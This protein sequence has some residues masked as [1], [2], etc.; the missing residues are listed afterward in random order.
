MLYLDGISI[1]KILPELK[2]DILNKKVGKIFQSS[3]LSL[4]FNFGKKQLIISCDSN[5]PIFY[6]KEEKE[7]RIIE[8]NFNFLMI[9]RKHIK[10]SVLKKLEQIDCDRI[11]KFTFQ[12]INVLGETE[13]FFLYLEIMG[14]SSN[15]ILTDKK[16]NIIGT[17]K[18][19]SMEENSFRILFKGAKYKLPIVKKKENPNLVDRI[20][21]KKYLEEEVILEKINGVGKKTAEILKT[22]EDLKNILELPVKPKI[23]FKEKKPLFATV[24]DI[25]PEIYD[26][27]KEFSSFNKMVN[28]YIELKLL[29]TSFLRLKE[30]L[31]KIVKK[32]LKK[33]Q[34]TIKNIEKDIN[35]MKDYKR[36]KELGDILA[37]VLYSIKKGDKIVRGYDFYK[38]KEIEIEINAFLSP[39]KNLELMYRKYSKLKKGLEISNDRLEIFFLR[40]KYLESV[41]F[42]IDSCRKLLELENIEDE[43]KESKIIKNKNKIKNKEKKLSYGMIEI[44]K[45]L[46]Y[47][48]RNNKE[49]DYLTFKFSNKRDIWFHVKD[50]PG[51]HIIVKKED[52][53]DS[54]DFI[55]KIAEYAAYYSKANSLEKV[56]VDYTERKN[57][58]KPKGSSLGFVTYKI[59]N[60]II[61]KTP[62][63]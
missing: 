30:K 22:Y 23:Y 3:P 51:S 48:G 44:N 4:N 24:L 6:L 11:I 33:S 28:E 27:I 50:I 32:E 42:F 2:V 56:T 61:V 5:F 62:N 20:K 38:N 36:Y 52:F 41:L 63:K 60:S 40:E 47:Y 37:S 15:L 45:K 14:K 43:L 12:K 9:L 58:N 46:I 34:K 7:E 53:I 16:E 19:F 1:F 29:S 13:N 54:Q 31:V 8:K 35:L 49:N 10:N 26:E 21:F 59:F 39:Q 57:L 55:E 18:N 25:K 17:L